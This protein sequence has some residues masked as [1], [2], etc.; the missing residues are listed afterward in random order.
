MLTSE[1]DPDEAGV[2]EQAVKALTAAELRMAM[3]GR[4]RVLV[5]NGYLVR[6]DQSGVTRLRPIPP[7]K[8][9]SIRIKHAKS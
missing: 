5:Q 9:V 7:R 2:P 1:T 4:P 8:K 3:T 6:I